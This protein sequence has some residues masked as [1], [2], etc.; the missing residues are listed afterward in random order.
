[1]KQR[2]GRKTPDEI[3]GVSLRRNVLLDQRS[4][5]YY[6]KM[7]NNNISAGLRIVAKKLLDDEKVALG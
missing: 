2:P 3:E 4:L 1:M 5:D 6:R 7:G